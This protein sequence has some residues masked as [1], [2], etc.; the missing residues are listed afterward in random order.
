MVDLV[1]TVEVDLDAMDADQVLDR[2]TEVRSA[3]ARLKASD[4]A[5]LDRLS[6]LAE[7]GEID[8]GGFSHNDYAFT[9]SPGRKS[10]TYPAGVQDLEAQA[11]AAKKAAEADGS[12]TAT[13][14]S[15][16]W[17]IRAPKP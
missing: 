4:E 9:W 11:K 3:M 7:T 6:V 13:T 5:L 16:F 10:W 8:Q 12:A 14:G 15:P 17:T 2:I 1:Q